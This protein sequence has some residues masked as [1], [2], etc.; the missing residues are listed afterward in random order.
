MAINKLEMNK[1]TGIIVIRLPKYSVS[2]AN[3][4]AIYHYHKDKE[5]TKL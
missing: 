5:T 4:A 3:I 1:K 2:S